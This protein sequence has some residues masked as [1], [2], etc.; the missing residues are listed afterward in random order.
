MWQITCIFTLWKCYEILLVVLL[1]WALFVSLS[2]SAFRKKK[3]KIILPDAN[4]FSNTLDILILIRLNILRA[5][6]LYSFFSKTV[7]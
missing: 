2:V 3:G 1:P 7:Y 6:K 4:S 5:I